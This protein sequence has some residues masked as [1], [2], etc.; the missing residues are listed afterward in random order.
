MTDTTASP[1]RIDAEAV[2]SALHKTSSPWRRAEDIEL[3]FARFTTFMDPESGEWRFHKFGRRVTC[4]A[5]EWVDERSRAAR[6][7]FPAEGQKGSLPAEIGAMLVEDAEGRARRRNRDVL[8]Y[9]WLFVDSDKGA[10]ATTLRESLDALNIYYLLTESATSFFDGNPAKWHLFLPLAQPFQ[11]PSRNLPGID[12]AATLRATEAWWTRVNDH[13]RGCVWALGQ[14]DADLAPDASTRDMA[15]VAY[16]PHS[17]DGRPRKLSGTASAGGRL[18]DLEAFLR[19]TGFADVAPPL[20]YQSE[21]TAAPLER[22][23]EEGAAPAE[24]DDEDDGGATAG[25]T[26]GSLVFRALDFFRRIG[27]KDAD[28]NAYQALCPWGENHTRG[29]GKGHDPDRFDDTVLVYV[30]GEHAGETGGFKCF[31]NGSG[32]PGECSKATAADVLRWARK[33]G[34]PLPDRPEW[35]GKAR[36]AVQEGTKAEPPAQAAP[37]VQAAPAAPPRAPSRPPLPEFPGAPTRGEPAHAP[38]STLRARPVVEPIVIE[39]TERIADMRDHAIRA[40][41]RH[42]RFYKA[43]GRLYDLA[44][45]ET[46]L[47]KNGSPTR[48]WLRKTVSMHLA[49]ELT[50]TST[51]VREVKIRGGGH[52]HKETRPDAAAVGAV[53]AAG[54]YPGVRQLDGIITS[55]VFR[56]SG[57]LLQRP[58]YDPELCVIYRPAGLGVAPI[59]TDPG[60]AKLATAK[61]K[62]LHIIADFPFADPELGRGVWLAMIFTRLLRFA[63]R[64]NVPLFAITA[65]Q[66]GSGKGKICDSFAIIAEGVPARKLTI[67]DD[68]EIDRVLG[69]AVAEESPVIVFDNIPR[70]ES[71][72]SATLEA[73]LTTPTFVTRRIG[74]SD[75]IQAE[76][77]GWTD[78]L[79]VATGNDLTTS[80]D[81]SRRSVWIALDDRTGRPEDRRHEIADLEA[82]CAQKRP[83]LL[84]AALTLLSGF[85]AAKRRGWRVELPNFA[86]FEGWG[87]VRE[88]VVWCGLPDPYLA[89]G[90]AEQDENQSVFALAMAHLL[91]L[92]GG[93][94]VR[95]GAVVDKL[96]Q[97]KGMAKRAHE[98]AYNFFQDRGVKL[99]AQES[100]AAAVSLGAFLKAFFKQTW[101][102]PD[103]RRFQLL[104][105]EQGGGSFIQ[106]V[107]VG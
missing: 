95:V 40:I 42:D 7:P 46:E 62:L 22:R 10:V 106:L 36:A 29:G 90:K 59:S 91:E 97:D 103:G 15:R 86:S 67:K 1:A 93:A 63:F 53:L 25:E 104:K 8:A 17:P 31:H 6:A 49:A 44:E 78:S 94:E 71:L 105:R 24:L 102:A 82:Y 51:W 80:G 69:A 96:R 107:A 81:M 48:P 68:A 28:P 34:C 54:Q 61:A 2:A 33:L 41:A 18:V 37:P 77:G 30:K 88:A 58:G 84:A 19:E 70:G 57:T 73:Y 89:R 98:A 50:R 74:T 66:A 55:P 43:G 99:E 39:V 26:T 35:G 76:K 20:V 3:S 56:R 16:L 64:G 4:T 85:F 5:A 21:K 13:V 14:L 38:L 75:M 9:T 92:T 101:I 65:G 27:P 87:L 72:K 23:E 47:D 52:E 83:E 11:L 60:A 12:D 32:R 100:R 79:L 45:P